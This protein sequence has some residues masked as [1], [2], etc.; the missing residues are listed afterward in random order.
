M[1]RTDFDSHWLAPSDSLPAYSK[2]VHRPIRELDGIRNEV[3]PHL[4]ASIVDHHTHRTRVADLLKELGHEAT[5]AKIAKELPKS[6]R[7]RKGNFGE[8]IASEHLVQRHGY[9]MPVFKLRFRDHANLPMRGEDIIAFGRDAAGSINKVCIGEAKTVLA[10][11]S[12]KVIDAHERLEKT[13]RPHP[14]TLHLI[15]EILY[16]RGDNELARQVD[17]LLQKLANKTVDQ[18]NW[19]FLITAN[20]PGDPFGQIEALESVV[21]NLNCVNLRLQNLSEFV[22]EL[23]EHPIIAGFP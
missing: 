5:A 4:G 15:A 3:K 13:Y 2:F 14:E 17:Q 11:A 21:P 22:T 16:D 6:D 8:V 10:F 20:Q 1:N 18:E 12:Q 9:Y 23:F 7:T 19:I